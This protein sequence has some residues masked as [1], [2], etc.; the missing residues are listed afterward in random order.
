M[1]GVYLASHL[2]PRAGWPGDNATSTIE[3]LRGL[4]AHDDGQ[5]ALVDNPP[6]VRVIAHDPVPALPRAAVLGVDVVLELAHTPRLEARARHLVAAGP[7]GVFALERVQLA[8]DLVLDE[9]VGEDPQP[10]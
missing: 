2:R 3:R 9:Q 5:L 10:V 8:Q 1:E 4:H 6:R 7:D